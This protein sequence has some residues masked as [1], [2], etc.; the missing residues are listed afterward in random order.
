MIRSSALL[1]VGSAIARFLGFLFSV[2]AARLLLPADYGLLAYALAIIG[3]SAILV[4]NAPRGL[5]G[6]L[7]RIRNDFGEQSVYF[8]NWLIVVA[9]ALG[10]SLVVTGPVAAVAGLSGWML[11]G[12]MANLLG[13]AV[14]ETDGEAQRGLERF[15]ALVAFYVLSNLL[16]LL[17]IL[18]AAIWGWRSP[19]LFLT[20]YG[21]SS[22]ATLGLMQPVAPIT[23]R[24]IWA[25]LAWRRLSAIA[26]FL[27][28]LV[29]QSAFFGLWFGADIIFV[30]HFMP[31]AAA[32]NYAAAK[33]LAIVLIMAPGAIANVSGPTVA[34]LSVSSLPRY[35]FGA[36]ALVAAVTVLPLA[37]VALFGGMLIAFTF[38]SK[39]SQAAE[40]LT[41]LAVG[42]G[43]LWL[44]PTA[45]KRLDRP[46]AAPHRPRGDR[47]RHARHSRA[48]IHA[49]PARWL[50][51][52]RHWVCRRLGAQIGCDRRVQY[53]ETMVASGTR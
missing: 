44:L 17:A 33:T 5:S 1:F 22:V 23:L 4:L 30:R 9:G 51:R 50:D 2:T 13:I 14:F 10:I 12:L 47:G 16:Q 46:G 31:P 28:P 53:L 40:P 15:P 18:V 3:V 11:V 25:A 27:W 48:G 35:L 39:Y 7:A 8:S 45:R 6:F 38:G 43:L 49:R 37:V 34:R 41:V 21:L 52:S 29:L 24:F 20:L 32:G 19:A 42:D 26:R 36:L